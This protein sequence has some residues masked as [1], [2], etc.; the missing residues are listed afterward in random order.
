MKGFL[1]QISI[2]LALFG[3]AA[4]APARA[5]AEKGD[6]ALKSYG[7]LNLAFIG[8]NNVNFG[9][10]NHDA[11]SPAQR[12]RLYFDYIAQK[13]L[14]ASFGV[15]VNQD[16]GASE[17]A[18]LGADNKDEIVIKRAM[19]DFL[20]PDTQTRVHGG[21]QPVGLPRVALGANPVLTGD[22]AALTLSKPTGRSQE[23]SVG[24]SRAYDNTSNNISPG[25]DNFF[26]AMH[27]TGDGYKLSPFAVYSIAGQS[28]NASLLGEEGRKGFNTPGN[29]AP[30]NLQDSARAWW[31]GTSFD[32]NK[33]DPFRIY[34]GAIYGA[35]DTSEEDKDRSGYYTDLAIEYRLPRLAPEVFAMYSSGEDG[36][37]SD[38]SKTMPML[39]NDE[40]TSKPPS[41]LIG[42]STE[43]GRTAGGT[44]LLQASPL[45][46]WCMGLSLKDIVFLNKQSGTVTVAYYQGTNDPDSSG[47]PGIKNM[48]NALTEE[49]YA[50]EITLQNYY[51]LYENLSALMEAGYA[52]LELEEGDSPDP[53]MRYGLGL[54]YAF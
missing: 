23:L 1:A 14:R 26:A 3:F 40:K 37:A 48:D 49:D 42:K 7:N 44:A 9:A 32:I 11:F 27:I 38:G 47:N 19:L 45:G 12:L 4:L 53:A 50:Y 54:K 28:M 2:C 52:K 34:G 21:I 24:W 31:A 13:H 17:E 35:L 36:E 51:N 10:K 41:M 22:M 20:W 6:S 33:F 43:M 16:W 39:Y 30:D 15:E 8:V 5:I 25:L 46:L 29:G 18:S